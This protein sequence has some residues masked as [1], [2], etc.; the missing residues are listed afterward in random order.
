MFRL[1]NMEW[2]YLK[3]TLAESQTKQHHMLGRMGKDKLIW[4][5]NEALEA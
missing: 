3:M 1:T 2:F 4:I 5:R